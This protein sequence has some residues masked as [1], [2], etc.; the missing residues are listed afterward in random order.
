M[1]MILADGKELPTLPPPG[2]EKQI[3]TEV[4]AFDTPG[5][6]YPNPST[7]GRHPPQP[8]YST[9][10]VEE[11]ITAELERL[12][13][14]PSRC[15]GSW[16]NPHRMALRGVRQ[17][18]SNSGLARLHSHYEGSRG[19]WRHLEEQRRRIAAVPPGEP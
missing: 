5:D 11:A 4:A 7:P 6:R 14:E 10:E 12:K 9:R 2:I 15:R 17:M 13:E 16:S 18:A 3:A 1:A 19:S 8:P